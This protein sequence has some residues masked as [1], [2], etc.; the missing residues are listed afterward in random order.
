MDVAKQF[1]DLAHENRRNW[2]Q[3][4]ADGI[5]AGAAREQSIAWG[6]DAMRALGDYGAAHKVEIWMEVHGRG[7][8]D[9]RVAAAMLKA[10]NHGNVG[11]CWNSKS[12]ASC[13]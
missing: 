4:A 1:V 2:R 6:A 12:M 8:S 11:A 10:A 9:P 7:T 5:R 13:G 3:A